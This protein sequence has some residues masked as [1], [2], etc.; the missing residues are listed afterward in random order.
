[1][2]P[3][4]TD[5]PEELLELLVSFLDG[6]STLRIASSCSI[7]HRIASQ[8]RVWETMRK[9]INLVIINLILFTFS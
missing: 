6:V 1:M 9:R 4:L 8:Q 5:L 3:T 2:P 7:L